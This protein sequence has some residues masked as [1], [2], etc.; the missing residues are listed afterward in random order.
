[1]NSKKIF[2]VSS[3]IFANVQWLAENV[4]YQANYFECIPRMI[5]RGVFFYIGCILISKCLESNLGRKNWAR[6]GSKTLSTN[7]KWLYIFLILLI[8]WLPYCILKYPGSEI[9]GVAAQIKQFL[10]IET[11]ARNFSA[12]VYDNHYL[13]GHHPVLLTLL[14]GAFV[15]F[16]I[17]IGNIDVGFF[18]YAI[19]VYILNALGWSYCISRVSDLVHPK[20]E[21][22][23]LLYFAL[24][25][26][27]AYMNILVMKDNLFATILGVYSINLLLLLKEQYCTVRLKR[28]TLFIAVLVP[29]I[30]NQGIYIVILSAFIILLAD[31]ALRR[32]FIVMIFSATVIFEVLFQG[33][34]MP[35]CKISP[36]GKQEMLGIFFQITANIINE[37][38]IPQNELEI[39]EKVIPGKWDEYNPEN[40]DKIKFS[41]NQQSTTEELIEYFK[42]FFRQA[43]RYPKNNFKAFVMQ[44]YGYW[45]VNYTENDM[46]E[47]GDYDY[48]GINEE[49]RISEPI[50]RTGNRIIYDFFQWITCE[51]VISVFFSVS[52]MFW[53]IWILIISYRGGR[54]QKSF[55]L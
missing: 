54:S 20:L 22:G 15:K 49:M 17:L 46:V 31:R 29:F 26:L 9:G 5:L 45:Y 3:F 33:I 12:V 8:A 18:L 11:S 27:I 13:S 37:Q 10:G 48:I 7:R 53:I 40:A 32:Y 50:F 55:S 39:I 28:W 43:W 36:G 21:G 42:V 23:L 47:F 1:M 25:P 41:Y 34:I 2:M 14:V 19:W 52:N 16:G 30:K 24:N 4:L 51:K 38:I 6:W 35:V 44:N